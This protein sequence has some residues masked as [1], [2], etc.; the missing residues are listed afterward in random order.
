MP[1]SKGPH[2]ASL[3]SSATL[4][5]EHRVIPL[6]G[7]AFTRI[8]ASGISAICR[9]TLRPGPAGRDPPT[10]TAPEGATMRNRAPVW[11]PDASIIV[12]A[13]PRNRG[14][15]HPCALLPDTI[16]GGSPLPP[17]PAAPG[18]H[19]ASGSSPLSP[20][21]WITGTPP[22]ISRMFFPS[23]SGCLKIP[24][25]LEPRVSST[26]FLCRLRATKMLLR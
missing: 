14:P 12:A 26:A 21:Q 18:Y 3:A 25:G 9:S 11:P 13:A 8:L 5:L 15:Y 17:R 16:A 23:G 10:P 22:S 1:A 7:K 6:P 19:P 24:Y 2:N 20:P 4:K